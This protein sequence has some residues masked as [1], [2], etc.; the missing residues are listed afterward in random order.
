MQT[1]QLKIESPEQ[2]NQDMID[3]IMEGV[4]KLSWDEQINFLYYLNNISELQ[5]EVDQ[6]LANAPDNYPETFA[7]IITAHREANHG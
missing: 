1:H 5:G 2:S 3:Q 4:S 7:Q 6:A